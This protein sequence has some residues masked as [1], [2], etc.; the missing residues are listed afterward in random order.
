LHEFQESY[1]E[2]EESAVSFFQQSLD[3]ISHNLHEVIAMLV[4]DGGSR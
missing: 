1:A 4:E 3:E 2:N